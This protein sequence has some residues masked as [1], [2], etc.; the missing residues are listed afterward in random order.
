MD[1]ADAMEAEKW[2]RLR[3]ALKPTSHR[4]IRAL[5][6]TLADA[7]ERALAIEE[8]KKYARYLREEISVET[9]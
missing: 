6:Q 7:G 3:V 8:A 5:M 1:R 2:R 9:G 4:A